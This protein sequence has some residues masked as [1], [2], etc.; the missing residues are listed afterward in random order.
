MLGCRCMLESG[1]AT[2]INRRYAFS[3]M[4]EF[5]ADGQPRFLVL[6]FLFRRQCSGLG[7]AGRWRSPAG[8]FL[9]TLL[10]I[11]MA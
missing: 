11:G 7:A 4:A 1:S 9:V 3:F 8:Q 5:A 10:G 2:K 6:G